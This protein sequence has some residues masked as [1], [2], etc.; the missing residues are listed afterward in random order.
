MTILVVFL[1]G[2]ILGTKMEE[3]YWKRRMRDGQ[4]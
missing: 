3:R 1:L 2:Y 4:G